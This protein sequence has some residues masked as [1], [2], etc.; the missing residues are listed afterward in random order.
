[1]QMAEDLDQLVKLCYNWPKGKPLSRTMVDL[2][3]RNTF[4]IYNFLPYG[5]P[6]IYRITDSVDGH[7]LPQYGTPH[8]YTGLPALSTYS[9]KLLGYVAACGSLKILAESPAVA[10]LAD[11]LISSY[12]GKAA[13]G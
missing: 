8:V 2:F 12:A 5:A 3:P 11:K 4:Q 13:Q 6:F 1:L 9:D 10:K 7:G